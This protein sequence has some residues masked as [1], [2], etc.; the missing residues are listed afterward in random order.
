MQSTFAQKAANKI[1]LKLFTWCQFHHE[2]FTCT[3]PKS[4][5]KTVKLSVFFA[6]SG[7]VVE[8]IHLFA[9]TL[10]RYHSYLFDCCCCCCDSRRNWPKKS[11]MKI[12]HL[13]KR[14]LFLLFVNCH[15]YGTTS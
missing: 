7:N 3:D 5:K 2:A 11:K 8:I 13:V 6:L 1:L 14:S 15:Y 10:N 12:V 9:Q 4:T